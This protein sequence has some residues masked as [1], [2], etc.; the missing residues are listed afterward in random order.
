MSYFE[1]GLTLSTQNT[2]ASAKKRFVS[3]CERFNVPP[4]PVS[5]EKLCNF[6]SFLATE[7]LSHKTIKCYLSGV[8]NL[9]L[10]FG[11]KDPEVGRMARLQQIIRGIKF[12]NGKRR[13]PCQSRL[14]ITPN[15]L[16]MIHKVWENSQEQSAAS[17]LW[18]AACLAFFGFLRT[19]EFTVPSVQSF[20]SAC[21]LCLEDVAVDNSE[22]P[23]RLYVFIK[24][25]KTDPFRQ[26][27]TLVLGRTKKVLCPVASMMA[28]LVIRGNKSGPLFTFED[29][30]FLTR[31]RFVQELKSALKLSGFDSD[32]YN[33]HSFRIGAATTAAEKGIEDSVIQTLGR[34]KSTAYLL[35][36]KLSREHLSQ[37]SAQLVS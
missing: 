3:F 25:S 4:L 18:A 37:V 32:N 33:G 36:V 21:H 14:P 12:D 31:A 29:G 7:G 28:F 26:G 19:A 17:L 6:A 20:D 30:S 9:Q 27:C 5:E 15:I 11:L 22:H 1:R 16:S 24:Q 13:V 23:S 10:A 2:Y 8:R 34:W 35:Y